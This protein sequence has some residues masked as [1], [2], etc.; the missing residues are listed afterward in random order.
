[1][2][3]KGYI[4][5]VLF[6]VICLLLS[7]ALYKLGLEKRYTRKVVH[8]LIGFEWVI[9]NHFFGATYH[10]LI[11]CLA[12]LFLLLFVY[13]KRLM[14][15]ISSDGDNS[16]GTVYYCISMSIMAFATTLEPSLMYPFGIAVFCTS[17]GDGFA[18]VIGYAVKKF[19]P[20]IWKNKTLV[21]TLA[22]FAFSFITAALFIISHNLD[23]PFMSG[24]SV[25]LF[26]AVFISL[27]ASELELFTGK[28]LDN[29][30]LPIGVCAL[31]FFLI[32]YN[33]ETLRYIVPILATPLLLAVVLDRKVLTPVGTFTAVI[34]DLAV[35]VAFGNLG[36][37]MMIVFLVGGVAIDKMKNKIKSS[38]KSSEVVIDKTRGTPQV[39]ANGLPAFILS[40]IYL[41]TH[42]EVFLVAF[43]AS[44]AEA[45]A[46]TAGSGFGVLSRRTVDIFRMK[47]AEQGMSG[48][49][50]L[51]GTIASAI[52]AAFVAFVPLWFGA[53]PL[54]YVIPIAFL[55]FLG[56]VFDSFLGSLF[57]VKFR[58]TVCGKLTERE[59]HCD[60]VTKKESGFTAVD[61]NFVN[62]ASGLFSAAVAI[63]VYFVF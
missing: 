56:S 4:F 1:M 2:I 15:M 17:F 36:F 5:G 49:V 45:F 42:K 24:P 52:A 19:N 14:P 48:G 57:Q 44:V 35:S 21:G 40:I 31:S 16:P 32:N 39:I 22:G 7:F 28:G 47:R 54:S 43:A 51:I 30:T 12:F 53:Y 25:P 3:L 13:K 50:S 55:G 6:A 8:I 33:D 60:A 29:I 20:R 9:L 27:L 38:R 41:F 59:C 63:V 46:D 61:N 18:G 10:L 58:C 37:V 34:L 26:S 11:V 62:L 23:K